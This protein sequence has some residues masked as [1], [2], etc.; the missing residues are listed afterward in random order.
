MS[1]TANAASGHSRADVST[2]SGTSHRSNCGEY[3]LFVSRNHATTG[4]ASTHSWPQWVRH[5]A[6]TMAIAPT[7]KSADPHRLRCSTVVRTRPS[8]SRIVQVAANVP[9]RSWEKV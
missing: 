9:S 7:P 8:S 2:S 1:A 5:P 4:V 3:T 6:S